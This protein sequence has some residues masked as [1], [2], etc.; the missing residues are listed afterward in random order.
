MPLEKV[1]NFFAEIPA[2][3]QTHYKDVSTDHIERVA[4]VKNLDF[5]NPSVSFEVI[6]EFNC[7]GSSAHGLSKL[8]GG[9]NKG[10]PDEEDFNTLEIL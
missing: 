1:L 4:N 5:A 9:M 10:K 7:K 3:Y 2:G 8:L 6:G